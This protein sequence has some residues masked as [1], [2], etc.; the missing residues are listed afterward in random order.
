MV[1][2]VGNAAHQGGLEHG[3]VGIDAYSGYVCAALLTEGKFDV[4]GAGTDRHAI[5]IALRE[6]ILATWAYVTLDGSIPPDATLHEE[7]SER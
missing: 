6:W 3:F 1:Y 5:P 2:V 7:R 4:Y